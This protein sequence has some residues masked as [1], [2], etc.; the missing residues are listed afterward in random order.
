MSEGWAAL[1]IPQE[2]SRK[3]GDVHPHG[4]P[5]M[6]L[7]PL[8]GEYMAKRI[9]EGLLLNL[10][11]DKA[12]LE[13]RYADY[14]KRLAEAKQRWQRA[15]KEWKERR[16]VSYHSD[17]DYVVRAWGLTSRH[18]TDSQSLGCTHGKAQGT[19]TRGCAGGSMVEQHDRGARGRSLIVYR[20][21]VAQSLR[22]RRTFVQ[23][24]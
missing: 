5:H 22:C 2:L 24:D 17:Y 14:T 16:V 15:A 8:A 7:D 1:D 23:L 6:N 20:V 4:N 21:R 9:Y 11:Q 19:A 13:A 18:R 12:R 10:P 3:D